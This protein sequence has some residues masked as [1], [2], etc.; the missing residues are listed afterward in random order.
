MEDDLIS[1][2]TH[3]VK[4]EVV[5]NYLRERRLIEVQMEDFMEQV[6]QVQILGQ[7]TGVRF[8]RLGYLMIHQDMLERLKQALMLYEEVYWSQCLGGRFFGKVRFIRVIGLRAKARFRKLVLEAYNRLY[9]WMGKYLKAHQHLDSECRALNINISRFQKNFDLL[10][11]LSF[12]RSLDT[13]LIER[14]HFMG[15]NFTPEE[16]VSIDQKLHI[17]PIDLDKLNVPAPM[18]LPQPHTMEERLSAM[19]NEIFGKYQDEAKGLMQ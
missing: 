4:V 2:L 18:I 5:E 15:E 19:A 12:L 6:K 3:E 10:T 13:S 11:I 8:S 14:K 16:M 17:S 9:Q 1:A 7:Q